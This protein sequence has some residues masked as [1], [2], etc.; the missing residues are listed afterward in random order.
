MASKNRQIHNKK[1]NVTVKW[2]KRARMWCRTIIK[3]NNQKQE[4]YSYDAKPS[5][6]IEDKEETTD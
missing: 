6:K 1:D 5:T 2:V 4:W 3:D